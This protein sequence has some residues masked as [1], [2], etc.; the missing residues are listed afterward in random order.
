MAST[1]PSTY[2]PLLMKPQLPEHMSALWALG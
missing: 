1:T 2:R